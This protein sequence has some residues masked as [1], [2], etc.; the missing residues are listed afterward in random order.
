MLYRF[1]TSLSSWQKQ[2]LFVLVDGVCAALALILALVLTSSPVTPALGDA[3]L[4]LLCAVVAIAMVVNIVFDLPRIRLKAFESRGLLLA[5]NF[6]LTISLCAAALNRSFELAV[7]ETQFV[8]MA[9]AL[10]V[11]CVFWRVLALSFTTYIYRRNEHQMRVIIYGASQTGQQLAAALRQGDNVRPVAFVDPDPTLQTMMIAGLRVYAPERL[12]SLVKER[13]VNRI[14]LAMPSQTMSEQARLAHKLRD[15]G[16]PVHALPSFSQLIK[17]GT[18]ER[19]RPVTELDSF[20]GRQKFGEDFLAVRESYQGKR[21]LITGAGGSIGSEL[22][23]QLLKYRPASLVLL[24]H[25]ELALYE[26]HRNLS[27]L[28]SEGAHP[29][30]IIPILGSVLNDRLTTKT[31]QDNNIQIVLHAAAYKHVPLVEDNPIIGLSNN[32]LGTKQMADAAKDAGVE[33]FILVSSDKAVRPTNVMGASKRLA[34]LVIQDLATR[35]GDTLFSMVRFG[36]V[37]G[38]SGSIVPLFQE[39]IEQ[40]GPVTLTDERATRF[41]MTLSEAAC[42]VLIAGGFAQGGD[43]F[44]LDMGEPVAIKTLIHQMIAGA[45]YSVRDAQNPDGDI[46]IK[47]TGLRKGE[48]LNE[49]LLI[50]PDMLATPHAKIMR[51]REHGLSEIEIAAALKDLRSAIQEDDEQ[52][53]RA[54]IARWVEGGASLR[55]SAKTTTVQRPAHR[56]PA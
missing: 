22:C 47:L 3:E 2:T 6:A 42:L 18:L 48:K 9:L 27:A 51:A 31:L 35:P 34:E 52:V 8:I 41:F 36:N 14:V 50:A 37:L 25:S 24:D 49:E 29:T 20:L 21:I 16:C 55:G 15:V 11:F 38:S 39:Q 30:Q 1:I 56:T 28:C 12:R 46:E 40:G 19:S 33:R 32:V 10:T 53:A 45:G 23:K 17:S 54:V 5:A 4:A 44:V 26:V 7:P 43:V 13:G